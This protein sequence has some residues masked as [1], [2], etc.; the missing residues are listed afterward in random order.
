MNADLS[1]QELLEV[2]AQFHLPSPVLVEKD[3]YVVKALAAIRWIDTEPF[4]LVFGGGTSLWCKMIRW[5]V[6][7]NPQAYA[8]EIAAHPP[9]GAATALLFALTATLTILTFCLSDVLVEHKYDR[10]FGSQ[11]RL[12]SAVA[13]IPLLFLALLLVF[14]IV[15]LCIERWLGF[16]LSVEAL[17]CLL[18]VGIAPKFAVLLTYSVR[19]ISLAALY[20]WRVFA[21]LVLLYTTQRLWG[22]I[23]AANHLTVWQTLLT[24]APILIGFLPTGERTNGS[25]GDCPRGRPPGH[26]DRAASGCQTPAV[27][28]WSFSLS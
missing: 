20:V 26:A 14:T 7:W 2:Q 23:S 6:L 13:G 12:W 16:T 18:V 4:R 19:D 3:Y 24:T 22:T 5:E 15:M 28:H 10:D 25:R 17:F 27:S 11:L 8:Q 21:V 9:L 1:T